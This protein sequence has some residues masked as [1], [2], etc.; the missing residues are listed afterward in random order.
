[1]GRMLHPAQQATGFAKRRLH[2]P[3]QWKLA[4]TATSVDSIGDG[5]F[6]V[7]FDADE[8]ATS[9]K[10]IDTLPPCWWERV[11]LFFVPKKTAVTLRDKWKGDS[12]NKLPLSLALK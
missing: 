10:A 6:Q 8:A 2:R 5:G 3:V 11:V 9:M 7:R 4:V 12:Q 1:M